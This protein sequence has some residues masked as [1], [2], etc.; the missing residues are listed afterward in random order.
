MDLAARAATDARKRLSLSAVLALWIALAPQLQAQTGPLGLP[1]TG[2]SGSVGFTGS[3]YGAS[4]ISGRRPTAR[5]EISTSLS[6]KLLGVESG[7]NVLYSTESNSLRQ[8]MN[9]VGFSWSWEWGKVKAGTVSPDYSKYS[10]GGTTLRGGAVELTPGPFNL[11]FSGGKAQQAVS[12]STSRGFRQ[13][14]FERWLYAARVGVGQGERSHFHLIGTLGRDVESSLDEFGSARP[15]ENL[16]VTPDIGI[17]M[18]DGRLRVETEATLSAFTRDTRTREVSV[19]VPVPEVLFTPRV[20]SRVDYAGLSQLEVDL[21]A[22]QL[23]A[24]YERVQPGFR[25]L[26]LSR[27]RSD[28]EIIRLNP[29]LQ[30]LDGKLAVGVD[31]KRTRNNLLG[32][33]AVQ[34]R[35]RQI[36]GNVRARLSRRVTISGSYRRVSSRQKPTSESSLSQSLGRRFTSQVASVSPTVTLRSGSVTHSISLSGNYQSLNVR[37]QTLSGEAARALTG[38]RLSSGNLTTTTSYSLSFP[39]GLSLSLSG[40]YLRS[41]ARR[42]VTKSYGGTLSAGYAF[43][44]R[45]LQVNLSGG[46]SANRTRPTGQSQTASQ[47]RATGPVGS[48]E[49]RSRQLRLNGTASYRL[50]F[51]D[52][53]RMKGRILSN[54]VRRG[55]GRSFRE[56]Q[57]TVRFSHNF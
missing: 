12:P 36:G 17:S 1:E 55:R 26:G 18:F 33:R 11:A 7:L 15:S 45:K 3:L 34:E 5:S 39:S 37:S 48:R 56:G 53:I 29:Q 24:A 46:W 54:R 10:L 47:P 22:F 8:S 40:N 19:G 2:V 9:R 27:V 57:L 20:G 38:A 32:Q 23:D 4:G 42:L 52:T 49:R 44:D 43:L 30:L 41:G 28:Q 6:F 51:G 35:Q 21:E 13:A 14:S 16:T 50:P 25:S 31:L